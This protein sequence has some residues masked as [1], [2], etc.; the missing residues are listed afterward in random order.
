MKGI[1]TGWFGVS[2]PV[3]K[4]VPQL[5]LGAPLDHR[6]PVGELQVHLH[7]HGFQ[8]G[9]GGQ[10]EV[11]VVGVLLGRQPADRLPLVAGLLQ[12][13]PWPGRRPSC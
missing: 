4:D 5:R 2:C 3:T 9:L 12:E 10:G 6:G 11:V 8:L 7:P 13:G 1:S